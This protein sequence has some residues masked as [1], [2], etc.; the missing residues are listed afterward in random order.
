MIKLTDELRKQIEE[1]GGK[2]INLT[3]E[4]FFTALKDAKPLTHNIKQN[5]KS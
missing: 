3:S 4:E 5:I 2:I 1:S